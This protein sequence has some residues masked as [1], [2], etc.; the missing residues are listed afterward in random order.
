MNIL[1]V[2]VKQ[3]TKPMKKIHFFFLLLFSGKQDLFY[4]QFDRLDT[5]N[6]ET[7]DESL[8]HNIPLT[9][10]IKVQTIISIS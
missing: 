9:V 5:V 3:Q 10:N 2:S 8:H 6:G 7:V 4:K 1:V